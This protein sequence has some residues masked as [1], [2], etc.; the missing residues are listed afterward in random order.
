MDI[1]LIAVAGLG[2]VVDVGTEEGGGGRTLGEGGGSELGKVFPLLFLTSSII[3]G[4]PN[5]IFVF[6][7]SRGLRS[8]RHMMVDAAP[9]RAKRAYSLEPSLRAERVEGDF[10]MGPKTVS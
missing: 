1:V 2:S 6:A 4:A 3:S 7:S 5:W 10:P 8:V 9:D